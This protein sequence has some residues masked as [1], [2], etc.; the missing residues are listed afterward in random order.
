MNKIKIQIQLGEAVFILIALAALLL[1]LI[2]L[3]QAPL[4]PD[5]SLAALRAMHGALSESAFAESLHLQSIA[6]GYELPTRIVF[7]FFGS[8]DAGARVFPALAGFTLC[9]TPLLALRKLGWGRV[10][11]FSG[12]LAFSPIT[13]SMSRTAGSVSLAALGVMIVCMAS[14]ESDSAAASKRDRCWTI[15][16][17]TLILLSGAQAMM[18]LI[19]LLLLAPLIWLKGSDQSAGA[20]AWLADRL[21]MLWIAPLLAIAL[22]SGLGIWLDGA[23]GIFTGLAAWFTGWTQQGPYNVFALLLGL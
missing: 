22:G 13:V 15:A 1:R 20:I 7:D 12:F 10:L 3:G 5:E 4:T 19:T 18:G 8:S 17:V 6:P 11:F 23:G 21:K 9:L 14:I 2:N 16:G